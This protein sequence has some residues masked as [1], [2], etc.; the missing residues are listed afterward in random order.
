MGQNVS[1]I[2]R[3][4][5]ILKEFAEMH[6]LTYVSF[7]I[8]YKALLNGSTM[9]YFYLRKGL[10]RLEGSKKF[11]KLPKTYEETHKRLQEV[12]NAYGKGVKVQNMV[13]IVR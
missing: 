12:L 11:H 13:R 8:D 4:D 1:S 3:T 6:N 10:Y 5:G 2:K 7:G 9:V